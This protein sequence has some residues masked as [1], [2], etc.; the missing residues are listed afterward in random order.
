MFAF[1]KRLLSKQKGPEFKDLLGQSCSDEEYN[2]VK[3]SQQAE[4]MRL[5]AKISAQGTE[6]LSQSEKEFLEKFSR[7]N[8]AR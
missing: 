7:S 2:R 3:Q 8:Y 6:S 5:L 4:V 1:I